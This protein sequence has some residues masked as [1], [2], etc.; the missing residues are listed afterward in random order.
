MNRGLSKCFG[1]QQRALKKANIQIKHKH[2]NLPS[3]E[4]IRHTTATTTNEIRKNQR[5]KTIKINDKETTIKKYKINK[6]KR[7]AI[8]QLSNTILITLTPLAKA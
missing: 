1:H 5:E 8:E 2:V 6:D 4:N 7:I 3:N